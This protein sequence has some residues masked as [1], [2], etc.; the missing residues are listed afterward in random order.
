MA[1][2]SSYPNGTTPQDADDFIVARAG[3]NNRLTWAGIKSAITL[4]YALVAHTHTGTTDSPK[5]AQANTHQSPD[6][7]AAAS[8]LHH[9]LGT[10]ATQAAAGNHA[11][12]DWALIADSTLGADA[13]SITF[14][15]IPATYKHLRLVLS[16]RSTLGSV[17]N[18]TVQ[19]NADTGANYDT[20]YL[21]GNHATIAAAGVA[22]SSIPY[23]G[24]IPGTNVVRGSMQAVVDMIIPNYLGTTFEKVCFVCSGFSDSTVTNNYFWNSVTNWRNT[25]AITEVKLITHSSS[26]W[27]AGTR[28]TLYGAK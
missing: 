6:T 20:Q 22:G 14:S 11:G 18:L 10:G 25:A 8:S 26:N 27:K 28:A 1:K 13:A 16:G 3:A 15:S 17:D 4:L 24:V 9:T 5:L 7:D 21:Y 2:I 12:H 23:A 19:F